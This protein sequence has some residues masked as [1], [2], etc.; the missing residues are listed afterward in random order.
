MASARKKSTAARKPRAAVELNHA[1]IYTAD[2]SRAL[3]FYR[4]ALG[5]RMIERYPGTY[6]RL[7]SPT[8]TT[9]IALHLLDAGQEMDAGREGLRLYFE[10]EGLDEFCAAL[11]EKG[12]KFDQ[13][14]QDM[15]WGWK[16]AYLRDPDGH[17]ISL[18]WA[19]EARFRKT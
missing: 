11:R 10:V 14:P 16:H 18:Y 7:Q 13:M 5:F 1:M 8:G 15:P 6:A 9:T 3:K 2:L 19:G 4:D 12:I 17:Q